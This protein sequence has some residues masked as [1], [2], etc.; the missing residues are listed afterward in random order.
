MRRGGGGRPRRRRGRLTTA[1]ATPA[2][3]GSRF[4]ELR[5]R[6][7]ALKEQQQQRQQQGQAGG[8]GPGSPPGPAGEALGRGLERPDAE[9]RAADPTTTRVA[10]ANADAGTGRPSARGRAATGAGGR[11]E[12]EEEEVWEV[13]RIRE[14]VEGAMLAALS[15]LVYFLG[16]TL[17]LEGYAAYFLPLPMAL[18]AQ[19]YSERAAPRTLLR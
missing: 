3:R 7:A 19:R 18:M 17:R 8:A 2:G 13:G 1:G 4:R 12:E 11:E 5:V 15:S 9:A 6:E 14:L 16:T 10:S